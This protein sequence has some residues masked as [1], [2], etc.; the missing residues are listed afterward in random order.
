M[1]FID[2]K[3]GVWFMRP[4]TKC[5]ANFY[6][7]IY[8]KIFFY[9]LTGSPLVQPLIDWQHEQDRW[10]QRNLWL[11]FVDELVWLY[12]CPSTT[13]PSLSSSKK[14]HQHYWCFFPLPWI[15]K[16]FSLNDFSHD[17]EHSIAPLPHDIIQALLGA[18]PIITQALF[19]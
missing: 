16:N 13:F 12:C 8:C 17:K 10:G 19:Q 5:D 11:F 14:S 6:Y 3:A 4:G 15:R 2:D 1:A 18:A 7:P 9:V